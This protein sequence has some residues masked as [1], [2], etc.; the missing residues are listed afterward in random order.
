[1][2]YPLLEDALNDMAVIRTTFET[3]VLFPADDPIRAE[4]LEVVFDAR[5]NLIRRFQDLLDGIEANQVAYHLD[6]EKI[7][8]CVLAL[9]KQGYPGRSLNKMIKLKAFDE[10]EMLYY[11]WVPGLADLEVVRSMPEPQITMLLFVDMLE[12]VQ[13][14]ANFTDGTT[15]RLAVFQKYIAIL[16]LCYASTDPMF[17]GMG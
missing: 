15:F 10:G 2:Q 16:F 17:Y 5:T 14:K 7:K 12:R 3:L 13:D 8:Q 4:M 6:S 11:N 1:M 9:M